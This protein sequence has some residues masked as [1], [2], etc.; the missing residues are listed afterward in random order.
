[1]ATLLAACSDEVIQTT[2]TA[3]SLPSTTVQFSLSAEHP[4]AKADAMGSRAILNGTTSQWEND[5]QI[6]LYPL[7]YGSSPAETLTATYISDNRLTASFKGSIPPPAT[8]D[9]YFAASPASAT[10]AVAGEDVTA[11]FEIPRDQE[12]TMQ[13]KLLLV[14]KSE[15]NIGSN[16]VKL[17]F[18]AVNAF[19]H[20]IV[21]EDVTL[22]EFQ[23]LDNSYPGAAGTYTYSFTTNTGSFADPDNKVNRIYVDH[24]GI[25]EFYITVPAVRYKNGY[26][27][28]LRHVNGSD[29]MTLFVGTRT[30]GKTFVAG[31]IYT[32][33][34]HDFKP[35]L[36]PVAE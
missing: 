34:V 14:A 8:E 28:T 20:M 5:D 2:P 13:P 6:V 31:K 16:G 12:A 18:A 1:M 21:P 33:T 26:M 4:G 23:G 25:N 36:P 24:A 27:L 3:P 35:D 9:T 15:E 10:I 30:G 22:T 17:Q 29:R 11:T 19:I 7:S 32:I